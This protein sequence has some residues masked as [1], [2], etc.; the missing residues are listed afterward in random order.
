ME[1]GRIDL[2]ELIPRE[3]IVKTKIFIIGF[4][5]LNKN[6]IYKPKI[7]KYDKA[8]WRVIGYLRS[9]QK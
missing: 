8:H 4:R 7:Q 1:R 6:L 2:N 3:R 9:V 5:F